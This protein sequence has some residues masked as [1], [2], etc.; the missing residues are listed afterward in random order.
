MLL[1]LCFTP[2]IYNREP[3]F[4]H[5]DLHY[6]VLPHAYFCTE[7]YTLYSIGSEHHTVT[8]MDA[9]VTDSAAAEADLAFL[10]CID[11]AS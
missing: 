7:T 3:S 11:V 6:H 1:Q 4:L 10:Q 5:L 9:P 2:S 8:A